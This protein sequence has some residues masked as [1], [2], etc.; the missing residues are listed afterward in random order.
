MWHGL[1]THVNVIVLRSMHLNARWFAR[2]CGILFGSGYMCMSNLS[3]PETLHSGHS[4]GLS[5]V[6]RR[7]ATGFLS[8]PIF[9]ANFNSCSVEIINKYV[10]MVSTNT[11]AASVI[12]CEDLFWWG[13]IV[14]GEDSTGRTIQTHWQSLSWCQSQYAFSSPPNVMGNH[15]AITSS[16]PLHYCDYISPPSNIHF[17]SVK[18]HCIMI[19]VHKVH[20]SK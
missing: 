18:D 13:N 16:M 1:H 20:V 5:I 8:Y 6:F 17:V 14:H 9:L 12:D 2:Q 11:P 10:L 4:A 3:T 19:N 7:C 15:T